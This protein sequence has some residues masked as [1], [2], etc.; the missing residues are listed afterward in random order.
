MTTPTALTAI[1][2][3]A[4]HLVREAQRCGVVVTIETT[5]HQPLAMGNHDMSV[6]VR[7]SRRP[8][9]D[10]ATYATRLVTKPPGTIT[11]DDTVHG[12]TYYTRQAVEQLQQEHAYAL[13]AYA[14][15]IEN[16]ELRH[17][18]TLANARTDE[19]NLGP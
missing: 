17:T 11:Q 2:R 4:L 13:L 10:A 19:K 6:T 1:H 7:E 15:T 8:P 14:T 12:E 3:A 18:Q 5:P 9:P 16:L